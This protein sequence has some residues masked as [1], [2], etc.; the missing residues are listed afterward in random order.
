MIHRVGSRAVLVDL[1]DLGTVMAWHAALTTAPLQGQ[2]DVIAAA[3]TILVTTNSPRAAA[4]AAQELRTFSPPGVDKQAA[5]EVSIDVVYDGADLHVAAELAGMSPA[6]LIDWHTSQQWRGA[7]GGFAPGFTY[8]VPADPARALD[9]PRRE[10]PRTEVPAGAVGL[11]GDFSAVYPRQSPGGWQLIGTTVTPMWDSSAQPPAL[12]APGDS[13]HYR[14]VR[15]HV[16]LS[17]AESAAADFSAPAR[18]VLQVADPGLLTL[19]QDLGR[20]GHG[21]L[22]VTESGAADRASARAANAAVGNPSGAAVLE[23]IG[24]LE[25]TAL[26]DTVVAVTGARSAVT[27]E[28]RPVELGNAV[29]LSSGD[30]LHVEAP[31]LGLR[32]Y[33]AVRGGLVDTPVLGSQATDVLSGLGPRAITGGVVS[34]GPAPRGAA[35]TRVSNPLRV[36]EREGTTHAELR[37]VP[38]PREDWFLAGMEALTRQV[39][40]V[41]GQSNRV[42]L[43]LEGEPLERGRTG[44]L[45]SEGIVAGSVQIPANGLPVV[46]LRDHPVTGGYPVVA[47]VLAEDLDIA[48][49]LPPGGTV[50]FL[51][52]DPESRDT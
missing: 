42:G 3:R 6:A 5:D 44:E 22:G 7:F 32:S 31:S 38:G 49:Q 21:N 14:A 1:P 28:D 24:G 36:T 4:R 23:N 25:L 35:A 45:A 50:S 47:T 17:R 37:C 8:C 2:V 18:P 16:T 26:V 33:V 29:L 9:I 48:A 10:S 19:V 43:R 46:F 51:P 13:V 15:E 20:P 39:W 30:T 27:V 11:A 41:S 40:Q 52:V 34:A 12:I